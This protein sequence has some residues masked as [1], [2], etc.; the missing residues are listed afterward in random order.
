M[1]DDWHLLSVVVTEDI[2]TATGAGH[3]ATDML[4]VI[5]IKQK[6]VKGTRIIFN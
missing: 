6:K 3:C 1:P 5:R 4:I 2:V